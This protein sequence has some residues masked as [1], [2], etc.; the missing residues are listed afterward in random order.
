MTTSTVSLPVWDSF[1]RGYHWLQAISIAGLWYTGTEGLMD[2]H[3]AIAYL[4][5]A[6]LITR[7]IWGVIGSETAQFHHFVR[8]PASVFKYLTKTP[9]IKTTN[10]AGHNPAGAYMVVAFM[11]L[12]TIQLSTGLFANDDILSE[13]PLALYVSSN[14][15]STLTEIH[16][17]NFNIILGAIILHLVAV[18]VYLLKQNNLISPMFHGKKRLENTP[19]PRLTNSII[20]WGIFALTGVL[21]YHLWAKEV[22]HYLF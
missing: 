21:I 1:V 10:Y 17:L 20:A 9:N 6:L 5:M 12:L 13:G 18:L 15:S 14:L 16:A 7:L 19:A 11:V 22:I 8:S 3:F 2:W 4:L